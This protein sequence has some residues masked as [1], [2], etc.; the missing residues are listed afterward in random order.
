VRYDS[1]LSGDQMKER[2]QLSTKSVNELWDLHEQIVSLLSSKMN[3][4]KA[5]LEKRLKELHSASAATSDARAKRPYPPVRP[6]YRD[7][8]SAETWAGRGK[9]PRWL[10]AALKKGK[11]LEDF[12]IAA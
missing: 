9:R 8:V 2:H 11:H 3:E 7:P 5:L 12:R 1:Q 4:E 10:V 6:K